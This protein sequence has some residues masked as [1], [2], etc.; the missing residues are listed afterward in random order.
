MP[1][2]K[3]DHRHKLRASNHQ[4]GP[5]LP[6]GTRI[7]INI[8]PSGP[9]DPFGDE[10]VGRIL[11]GSAT[12]VLETGPVEEAEEEESLPTSEVIESC[13]KELAHTNAKPSTVHT[14]SKCWG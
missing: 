4:T 9:P 11:A 1:Y 5:G 13:L 12:L 14:Y 10:L 2:R 3:D 7:S 6:P 8:E